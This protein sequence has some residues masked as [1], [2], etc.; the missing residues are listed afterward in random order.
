MR[1]Y[2]R[3]TTLGFMLALIGLTFTAGAQAASSKRI[4]HS[5]DAE[6]FN[7]VDFEI[8]VAELEIEVYDGDTVEIDIDLRADRDWWIFGR[9]DVDDVDLIIRED[10]DSLE[11][12]LD[13]D[14]VEQDRRV[15]LPA[16]MAV[17]MEM[18]VG[19]I[20]IEGFSNN[21]A[22]ELGVGAVRVEVVDE[23]FDVIHLSTGVGD[24]NIRG[25]DRGSDNER[26]FVGADSFYR[27]EGEHEIVI[28]VGVGDAS[29][30][31]D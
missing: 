31:R 18:G 7:H 16:H 3:T 20:D 19:E 24:S 30:V 14:D 5:I 11:L 21:L 9:G 15:R 17:S 22:L 25:F 4:Q 29:V 13:E 23:D 6:D 8:S 27:G 28:E 1:V 26:N 12:I 2:L 10:G